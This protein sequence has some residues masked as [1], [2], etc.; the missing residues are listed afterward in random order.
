MYFKR[1]IYESELVKEELNLFKMWEK[2]KMLVTTISPFPTVLSKDFY[3]RYVKSRACLGKG[4][5]C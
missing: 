1:Q 4:K 3:C 5:C 2:E